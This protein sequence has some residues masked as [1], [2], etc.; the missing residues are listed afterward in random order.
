VRLTDLAARLVARSGRARHTGHRRVAGIRSETT[1]T[2]DDRGVPTVHASSEPDLYFAAGYA[3]AQDRRWQMDVL[4]RRAHGRLSEVL[5]PAAVAE[6]VRA[7]GL[8][9][10]RVA[11]ASERLLSDTCR[12]NLAAFSEG[13]NAATRRFALP[14]E[15]LLLRYRPEPWTP[16]D[17]ITLVKRLGFDLG[18]NLKYELFRA[19]LAAEHPEHNDLLGVP[20]YPA[21]GPVTI[22]SPEGA[23]PPAAGLPTRSR[24]WLAEL[25]TGEQSIGS[26]AWVLAGSRTST[27]FP[28]LAND[29][30]VLFTHPSLWY[31]QG[32][33]LPGAQGYGVTVPG[34]PGLIAGANDDLAWGVTNS[35]VDTQDLC[36]LDGTPPC[37]RESTTITVRGAD[38]VAAEAA[39]GD[40]YVHFDDGIG[41]FWSGC[42]PSA[43]I[44]ACQRMWHAESYVDFREALRSF[45]VPVLNVAVATRDGTIAL[46]TAGQVP[47]RVRGSGVAPGPYA[48][49]ARSWRRF[50]EFDELPE[51]VDPPEGYIVSANHKLLPDNAPVD[52]GQDWVAPY[53]AARI[54]E[55]VAGS[56]RATPEDCARWQLDDL[57]GRA[58]KLLPA[59]LKEL[60]EDSAAYELLAHWDCHDRPEAHAPLVFM[61]LLQLVGDEWLGNAVGPDLAALVPDLTQLLDHLVL[62]PTAREALNT[63]ADTFSD[64]ATRI[65]PTSYAAVHRIVDPHPLAKAAAVFHRPPTPVGGSRHTVCLMA[66]NPRGEVIEGA[67]WRFVAELRPDGTRLWDVLRHGSSGHPRSPHYDDQTPAH[68]SGELYPM[69]L[70]ASPGRHR[71]LLTPRTNVGVARPAE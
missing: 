22:R 27:G 6:D 28:L 9:L 68:T 64:A 31:Q 35:T 33:R 13:V 66:P 59:L 71:L 56:P 24:A 2:R 62:D 5:G 36:T 54:E 47:H 40:G 1:I 55:L 46:R 70:T 52:V 41:L 10:T 23:A 12:A 32:L 50:L 21:D 61:R 44:E 8:A 38:D 18:L 29:P 3:Q 57:N 26:N 34:I 42:T 19:R 16:L 60:P 53:R 63:G 65:I 14:P 49:V 4:R 39:G 11:R 67:P 58:R 7:R 45:G 51:V 20:R 37:W 17:S 43:E 48:E 30:H 69:T 25:R 15:F